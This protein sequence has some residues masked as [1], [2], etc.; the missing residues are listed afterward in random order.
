MGGGHDLLDRQR[1][2]A[3]TSSDPQKHIIP[4]KSTGIPIVDK[5][6]A[7]ERHPEKED[8]WLDKDQRTR[9]IGD[10]G[11]VVGDAMANFH[12][13]IGKVRT[14]LLTTTGQNH[15][16][17]ITVATILLGAEGALGLFSGSLLAF[18]AGAKEAVKNGTALTVGLGYELPASFARG[19][20]NI[21]PRFITNTISQVNRNF[22]TKLS[23]AAHRPAGVSKENAA[24]ADFCSIFEEHLSPLA[25]HIREVVPVKLDDFELSAMVASYKDP[26]YHSVAAYEE[27]VRKVVQRFKDQHLADIGDGLSNGTDKM[28]DK[29]AVIVLGKNG[30]KRYALVEFYNPIYG[31]NNTR[32]H[33]TTTD[34]PAHWNEP[35]FI[36]W[37]DNDLAPV[38]IG[39]QM[40]RYGDM[41]VLDATAQ[42]TGMEPIDTWAAD[43]YKGTK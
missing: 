24:A 23:A 31:D 35:E 11:D 25:Q 40:D 17:W 37:I 36:S 18:Q 28:S 12:A 43:P 10:L 20:A 39:T 5:G 6:T 1:K 41:P 30:A 33:R 29:K 15:S 16:V 13:A 8:C 4:G 34:R 14:E 32:Y 42:A 22:K 21:N 3:G 2:A 9:L 26:T 38:A 27:V 19:I 7:C